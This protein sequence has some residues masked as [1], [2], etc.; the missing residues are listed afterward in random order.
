MGPLPGGRGP[1]FQRPR[2]SEKQGRGGA[3]GR[4][5][6]LVR[7]T[8]G[9]PFGAARGVVTGGPRA[10]PP[11]ASPPPG[12]DPAGPSGRRSGPP[13]RHHGPQPLGPVGP[14][15]RCSASVKNGQH[16][17]PPRFRL[18]RIWSPLAPCARINRPV[19]RTS[20]NVAS[21]SWRGRRTGDASIFAQPQAVGPDARSDPHQSTH[22]HAMVSSTRSRPAHRHGGRPNRLASISQA[23]THGSCS[24]PPSCQAFDVEAFVEPQHA[25]AR[26]A[27]RRAEGAEGS[28][29]MV[30]HQGAMGHVQRGRDQRHARIED[31]PGGMGST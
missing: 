19:P 15:R 12:R 29:S 7:R 28:R 11:A 9:E 17:G 18:G 20:G 22:G 24:G 5:Q 25:L 10:A 13:R 21:R 16:A 14:Y 3:E 26:P 23:I 6:S 2:L 30:R 27:G 8:R 31:D 4:A 1:P